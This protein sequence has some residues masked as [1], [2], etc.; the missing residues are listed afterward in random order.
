MTIEATAGLLEEVFPGTRTA[1]PDY[2]RWLYVESPFGE[3]IEANS[4]D[5]A[6]RA[7]HYAIVPI[8]L[9]ADGAPRRGAL[10]LNTAVSERA[11]GRG[12]FVSLAS[13][14]L[15]RAAAAG[16]ET[17]IGVANANSTPGFERRLGFEVVTALPATVMVPTPGR[18]GGVDSAWAGPDSFAPGS[19]AAAVEPLLAPPATGIARTWTE[20]TLRWRLASPG[21]RYAL[22]RSRDALAVSTVDRQGRIPVAVLLKVFAAAPLDGRA[23][24]AIVRAACRFH[25]A[26]LA[27]H[28]GL[29]E[30]ARFKG[31][32]LPERLRPSPLNLIHRWLDGGPREGAVTRLEFLDFDAY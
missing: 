4:D 28:V 5:D 31:L 26:P 8:D 21:A 27:L 30:M 11:R 3:A 22:H 25:R 18:T 20:A 7:G 19:L 2:L 29:N 12:L 15:E 17:V 6:G 14:T 16:V 10:S 9:V 32:P 24:R 23:R 13:E 1:R